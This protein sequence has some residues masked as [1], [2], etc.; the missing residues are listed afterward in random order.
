MPDD[1]SVD[2]PDLKNKLIPVLKN[3]FHDGFA[4]IQDWVKDIVN[5]VRDGFNALLPFTSEEVEFIQT[6]RDGKGIKPELFIRDTSLIDFD[7]IKSH[8][9]LLWAGTK[10]IDNH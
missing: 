4:T 3:N 9:A 10:S 7:A 1:I 5:N 6:I 8:P 2:Y